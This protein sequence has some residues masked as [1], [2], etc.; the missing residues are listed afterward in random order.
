MPG[1]DVNPYIAMAASLACGYLGLVNSIDPRDPV[2]SN[3][4]D[5]P[6]EF[7]HGT[8]EAL[9]RLTHCKEIAAVLGERF[10]EL[11]IGMKQKEFAEYFRVIS[12]WERKFLLLHV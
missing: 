10:V 7:P 2:A 4:Y 5:V 6:T 9:V 1:V 12:P 8:E 3:A 11:F